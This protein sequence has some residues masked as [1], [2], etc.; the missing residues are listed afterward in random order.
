MR[1]KYRMTLVVEVGGAVGSRA[2]LPGYWP[3]EKQVF[4]DTL[5]HARESPQNAPLKRAKTTDGCRLYRNITQGDFSYADWLHGVSSRNDRQTTAL[6]RDALVQA[7]V[8]PR[9]LFE[10][11]L[12][13]VRD[14]RP[15]L[16]Q[17]LAFLQP[18]D[19]LVVW[20]LDRL[21][22]SLSHLLQLINQLKDQ[23]VQFRSLTEQM[24]TTT[25]QGEFLFSIFG[26]LAQYERSLIRERVLAGLESA[27]W[28]ATAG[29]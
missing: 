3:A 28:R 19:T 8:Y 25:P 27:R 13:G 15:G 14:E 2:R 9:H 29:D 10:D 22:R 21:G 11:K 1:Y 24:D 7:G 23:G 12:S 26:A 17:S 18:G 20:K 4:F 16:T 6:Q 5:Y